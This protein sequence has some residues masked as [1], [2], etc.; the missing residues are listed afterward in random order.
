MVI[1]L[2]QG[3]SRRAGRNPAGEHMSQ[4]PREE[5][6]EEHGAKRLRERQA[7]HLTAVSNT[8][9]RPANS[10]LRGVAGTAAQWLWQRSGKPDA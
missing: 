9:G 8:S 7:V 10:G 3:S 5:A 4:K 2:R 6:S 1:T